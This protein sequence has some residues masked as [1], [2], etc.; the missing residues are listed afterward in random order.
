MPPCDA[1][2]VFAMR[3]EYRL[4]LSDGRVPFPVELI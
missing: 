2:S 4:L 1:V 3:A